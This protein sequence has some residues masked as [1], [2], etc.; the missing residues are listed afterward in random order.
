M[1]LGHLTDHSKF[2]ARRLRTKALA[3]QT[4]NREKFQRIAELIRDTAWQTN[5]G[6][7]ALV[8]LMKHLSMNDIDS[9]TPAMADDILELTS[10]LH[11]NL[12]FQVPRERLIQS[13]EPGFTGNVVIL[14]AIQ[15][16][17]RH[18]EGEL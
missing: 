11:R 4:P 9:W 12:D 5:A 17:F 16:A 18:Q 10:D 3:A 2:W 13:A 7:H 6:A 1:R 14:K 8:D 15:R